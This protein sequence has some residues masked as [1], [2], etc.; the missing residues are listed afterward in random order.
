VVRAAG[1]TAD[2]AGVMAAGDGLLARWREP[3]RRYHDAEHLAE[4][5][6]ALDEL[7]LDDVD[8]VDAAAVRLAAWFHDAVYEGRPGDDEQRSAA[9]AEQVLTGLGVPADRAAQVAELVRTTLHHD[10]PPGDADAALLCDADLAIL[11]ADADRYARY[12]RSVR[13]EYAHVPE[14]IFRSGR[15]LVLKALEAMP[16]LYRTAE[17][18][19]RWESVAR[20][21]LAQE[22][23]ALE[24]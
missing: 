11:A 1:A 10:P 13:E 22:L 2:A 19:R 15:A 12:V 17:G 4:V 5:L 23:A 7:G 21:N 9:L 3:H 18:H 24:G 6:A 16:R 20:A 14:P 8:G